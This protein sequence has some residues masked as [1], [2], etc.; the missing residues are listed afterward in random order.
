[1]NAF[2][3]IVAGALGAFVVVLGFQVYQY[4]S[5]L[6]KAR[7]SALREWAEGDSV[8]MDQVD[9]Y[10]ANC[11]G[12]TVVDT[13]KTERPERFISIYECAEKY[14]S[15]E[16]AGVVEEVANNVAVPAPLRWL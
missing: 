4:I 8:K 15:K 5:N 3:K 6:E 11:T 10:R 14:G 16:L 12:S 13:R 2:L 1:M 9:K 7:L